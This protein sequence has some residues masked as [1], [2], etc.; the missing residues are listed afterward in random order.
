VLQ[1]FSASSG[2]AVSST[3][4][5]SSGTIAGAS[6]ISSAA[7]VYV[8][9]RFSGVASAGSK[10]TLSAGSADDILVA[11]FNWDLTSVKWLKSYGSTGADEATDLALDLSNQSLVMT[12]KFS[13]TVKGCTSQGDT[14]IFLATLDIA[15]GKTKTF[16]CHGSPSYDEG[17]KIVQAPDGKTYLM[18]YHNAPAT[19]V[20]PM[21][22]YFNKSLAGSGYFLARF[23]LEVGIL[24][25]AENTPG[26]TGR[27]L[28]VNASSEALLCGQSGL[29]VAARSYTKSGKLGDS[30]TMKT[31]AHSACRGIS[32][33]AGKFRAVGNY[34]GTLSLADKEL[35][36]P[37]TSGFFWS[38]E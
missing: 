25:W 38:F 18:G 33:A 5:T 27:A 30:E 3:E 16:G 2:A 13:G 4:I 34:S 15:D 20:D 7:A 23:D 11:R 1:R 19:I 22:S 17:L 29:N 37:M 24:F 9:G 10:V 32:Y 35:S 26:F 14:D 12:G 28:G 6:V 21:S 31:T 36:A 8:A